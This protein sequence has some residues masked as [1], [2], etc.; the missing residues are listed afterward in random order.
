[1]KQN[2]KSIKYWEIKLIKKIFNKKGSKTKEIAIKRM[3][4]KFNIKII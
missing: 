1:M 3:R 2:S 4:T